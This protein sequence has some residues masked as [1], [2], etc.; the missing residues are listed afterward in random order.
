[1]GFFRLWGLAS[2]G[3]GCDSL[4]AQGRARARR[5]LPEE[6]RRRSR[7]RTPPAAG[8]VREP[9]PA[10]RRHHRVGIAHQTSGTLGCRR[11]EVGGVAQHVSR[12]GAFAPSERRLALWIA[13]PSAIGSGEGHA[14]FQSHPRRLQPSA[15]RFGR[16]VRHRLAVMKQTR[17]GRGGRLKVVWKSGSL[18]NLA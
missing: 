13:G 5:P 4:G 2:F 11:A 8:S 14:D 3:I 12:G 16:R 15:S 18:S 1:M 6:C 9:L 10:P 7:R 17:R